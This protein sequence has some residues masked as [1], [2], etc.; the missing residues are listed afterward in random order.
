MQK[1]SPEK[2]RVVVEYRI[3]AKYAPVIFCPS[4]AIEWAFWKREENVD[5]LLRTTDGRLCKPLFIRTTNNESGRY[6]EDFDYLCKRHFGASF[7]SVRS[8]WYARLDDL[9][10][11]WHLI[12]LKEV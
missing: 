5:P 3:D 11:Y 1:K 7:A 8:I 4:N 9:D 2:N 6:D 10:N 12:E